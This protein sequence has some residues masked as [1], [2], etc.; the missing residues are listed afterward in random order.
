MA[1]D[2]IVPTTVSR[3]C[4]EVFVYGPE[5]MVLPEP[6]LPAHAVNTV[7]ADALLPSPTE[8]VPVVLAE[9]IA[10]IIGWACIPTGIPKVRR[11]FVVADVAV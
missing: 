11:A 7:V 4:A 9:N 3:I 2:V 5:L 8:I 6:E 10:D 1:I